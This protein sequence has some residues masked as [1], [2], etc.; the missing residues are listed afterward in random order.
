MCRADWTSISD[1]NVLSGELRRFYDTTNS[2]Y[3]GWEGRLT[4]CQAEC[5]LSTTCTGVIIFRE[6]YYNSDWHGL[7]FFIVGSATNV[8][9]AYEAGVTSSLYNPYTITST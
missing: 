1:T 5:T 2:E 9:I 3:S 8:N 4:D 7:C 6:T